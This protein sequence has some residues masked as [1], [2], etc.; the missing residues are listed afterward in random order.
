MSV[1]VETLENLERKVIVSLAWADINAETDKRLKQTQRRVKID[2]FR[3]GKAPLKMVASM[4]GASVQNEV[5]N[6]LVQRA[7]YDIA[8]SE[9]LKVA[10]FP[11]FEGVEE[12]DDK[13]S[14][15]IAAI[16]EVFPEVSIG[17]LSDSEI[18]KVTSEVGDAEVEKT[19]EIL[20]KQRTRFNHVDRAAQNSDRV[21]IDFEGK[22]DGEPFAGGS[23][24]N[25]A[26]VLGSGQMLPEFE[27]GIAGMKAGESK[28]VEVNFPE[29]YHGKDVAGKSAVFTITL[30]NVSEPTLPEVD[31]DFAKALGIADGDVAKMRE[32]VK[33]NIEREVT[34]RVEAQTKDNVM[35]ALL[36]VTPVELPKTL[37]REETARM[38]ESAR[39]NLVSQGM[40]PEDVDLSDSLLP[41]ER[42]SRRLELWQLIAGT[43]VYYPDYVHPEKH[44]FVDAATA[45]EILKNQ[46]NL[47]KN[48]TNL[49]R[50]WF[51]KQIGKIRQLYRSLL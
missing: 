5:M 29:D 16:F 11:R 10:G 30:N 20:R 28:D 40:K 22:I 46:K 49:Y 4:Y 42:R 15:K 32:E 45:V 18:E 12:Q 47:Q 39:Q 51:E 2:G 21:I 44:H 1:T 36:D 8:V 13:D 43:L 26:F 3:P 24:K 50:N 48:N 25:Y 31:A 37:V 35:K 27:A 41:I 9:N 7:F 33:K 6:E 19:V 34:R 38:A 23:S 14:L 17:D